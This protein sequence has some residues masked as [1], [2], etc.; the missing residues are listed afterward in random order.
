MDRRARS[1]ISWSTKSCRPGKPITRSAPRWSTRAAS[2]KPS[3]GSNRRSARPAERTLI[4][5]RAKCRES[6]GD[7]ED[8]LV[9]FRAVFDG[10]GDEAAAIEY[11][12]FVF[13]HGSPDIVLAAVEQ[14]LPVLGDDY[15]Q[16]FLTSAAAGMLRAGRRDDA[17]ALV[18]RVAGRKGPLGR[19][20]GDRRIP[21]AAIWDAGVER[22]DH[23]DAPREIT[24]TGRRQ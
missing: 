24:V 1:S 7:L 5:N 20:A 19:R 10:F 9:G 8:A 6:Q 11:V 3:D 21:R 17:Q 22:S 13:R 23:G 14:A 2:R 18:R 12:N 4:L 16:A 15:R